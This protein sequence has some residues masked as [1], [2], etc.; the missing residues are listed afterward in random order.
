MAGVSFSIES[1]THRTVDPSIENGRD[2]ST[3]IHG[4]SNRDHDTEIILPVSLK[5]RI[6]RSGQL[7]QVPSSCR[8]SAVSKR[9]ILEPM[10]A[11]K[12]DRIKP[13][14]S[15]IIGLFSGESGKVPILHHPSRN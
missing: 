7:L 13:T 12:H 11:A 2:R 10:T 15:S 14:L 8:S 9:S 6:G 4:S 1:A 5:I 3:A